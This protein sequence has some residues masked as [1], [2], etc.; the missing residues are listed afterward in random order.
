MGKINIYFSGEVSGVQELE[1]CYMAC[2]TNSS[3]IFDGTWKDRRTISR[4]DSGAIVFRGHGFNR[5]IDGTDYNI[6]AHC[7]P[8]KRRYK[9]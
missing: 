6:S 1:I 9:E 4:M 7:F 5:L 8:K 3:C 2:N